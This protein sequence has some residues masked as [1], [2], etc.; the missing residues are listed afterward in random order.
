[1]KNLS[2]ALLIIICLA[3]ANFACAADYTAYQKD[4][5]GPY[6]FYKKAIAL[7]SKKENKDKAIPV[8]EKFIDGWLEIVE[9]YQ[10][11]PPQQ[12][13]QIIAFQEKLTRPVA[14]GQEALVLLKNGKVAEAHSVLEEVRYL[15]W[16]MRVD[17]G[18]VSLN[19]KIND[20]H[21]AMEIILHGA[22]EDKDAAHLKYVG[23]RYGAWVALKWE[24]VAGVDYT[25]EDRAVFEKAVAAGRDAIAGL[26]DALK[27]GDSDLARKTGGMVKKSYKTIFFLPACS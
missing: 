2:R 20:F 13:Q 4:V 3:V 5:M 18:I 23:E 22:S 26:R 15:L 10:G 11:D 6:G 14:V 12:F 17:A 9:K 19:D 24:D 25:A 21:E 8:T 16:R 1:M 27:K 7:T